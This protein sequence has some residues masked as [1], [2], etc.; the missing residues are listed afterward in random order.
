ME[1]DSPEIF[2]FDG[3]YA[4]SIPAGTYKIKAMVWDGIYQSE[5]YISQGVGTT[6]FAQG[7][8]I[9]VDQIL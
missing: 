4:V 9:D 7:A 1:G 6:D 2:I 3:Q 5:Y 8:S